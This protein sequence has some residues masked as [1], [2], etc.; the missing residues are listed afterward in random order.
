MTRLRRFLAVIAFLGTVAYISSA[1]QGQPGKK[2]GGT[3]TTPQ[4]N[5]GI[6]VS[7]LAEAPTE[8]RFSI[9][10][11]LTYLPLK[12]DLYFALQVKPKLDPTPVP[13]RDTLVMM[14]TAA[15]QAGADW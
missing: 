3:G 2:T 13:P 14:S 5:P 11:V 1:L 9:P 7:D 15:T 6:R 8:S 10:G 4:V 12:G